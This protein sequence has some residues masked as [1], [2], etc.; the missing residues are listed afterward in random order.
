MSHDHGSG[1][2]QHWRRLAGALGLTA[3]YTVVEGTVGIFSGSLVL[4]ADA[5]HMLTDVAALSLSLV[6]IWFAQ[7]PASR[8]RTFG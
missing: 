5:G 3:A 4:I 8:E 1:G 7:R 2:R 6:A